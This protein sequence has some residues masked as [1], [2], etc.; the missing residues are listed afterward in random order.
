VGCGQGGEAEVRVE[1]RP[2]GAWTGS[3]E[4]LRL[5]RVRIPVF[6]KSERRDV[7][8]EKADFVYDHQRDL[9]TCPC[10]KELRSRQI[11]YKNE[12]QQARLRCLRPK[13]Q[14]LSEHPG[15]QDTPLHP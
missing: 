8:F 5:L 15:A 7:T 3:A 4:G 14:M 13:T 11:T 6:D 1:V 10:G 9:Y 12:R 2:G